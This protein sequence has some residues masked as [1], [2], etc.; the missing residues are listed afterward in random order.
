[1]KQ[2]ETIHIIGAGISG[3][4]A[5]YELEQAGFHPVIIEKKGTSGGRVQTI[6]VEDF[7]L[8]LGFQVLLNAY[9]LAK[10]YLDLKALRL[11]K[12]E[13]STTHLIFWNWNH[14]R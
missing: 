11:T 1:M 7:Q 14:C 9:P 3:L 5:A 8:D 13:G 6:T 4:I 2:K 10:K 12:L